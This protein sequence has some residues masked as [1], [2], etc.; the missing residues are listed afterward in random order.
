LAAGNRANAERIRDALDTR[1][2]TGYIPGSNLALVYNALGDQEGALAQ[3]ERGYRERDVR[4]TFMV[5]DPSWNNLRKDPRFAA[6]V[7]RM[8]FSGE[9]AVD[10]PPTSSRDQKE[11]VIDSAKVRGA[12]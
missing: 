2:R 11:Y 9:R 10:P 3:L 5:V 1:A 12:P 6:L 4:M 7:A 8:N